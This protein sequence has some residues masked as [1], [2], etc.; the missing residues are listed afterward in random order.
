M[1][2]TVKGK[3][4]I[5]LEGEEV[6]KTKSIDLSDEE[7]ISIET[8]VLIQDMIDL[9]K[10]IPAIGIAAPQLGISKSILV[11]GLDRKH[12]KKENIGPIPYTHMINPKITY[13]SSEKS[14]DYEGCLSI[15]NNVA[16]ISRS[17]LITV[18]YYNTEG[19]L[20]S[21]NFSGYIARVIQHEYDH[22]QGKLITQHAKKI[23]ATDE[24]MNTQ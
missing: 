19:A 4:K 7:I 21:C 3:Y 14:D 20:I 6:L 13:Y 15:K 24:Y 12:P 16:L 9:I 5:Y 8:K 22:L 18:D 10:T 1:N 11:F 23:M 2:N 17:N